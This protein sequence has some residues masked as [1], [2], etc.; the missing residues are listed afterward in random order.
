MFGFLAKLEQRPFGEVLRDLAQAAG[1]DLPE[2]SMSPAE[3]QAQLAAESERGQMLRAVEIATAFFEAEFA[4]PG[5]AA[6]RAYVQGRGLSPETVARFR[7]GFAPASWNALQS[8]LASKDVAIDVAERVGL[9]GTNERGHYAFFRDRVMLPVFDRQKRPVG[10]SSRLLDP[11]AKDRKYVN[12]PDSPLFH[13]KEQLYVLPLAI[14]AIRKSGTAVVVEGN[15]DVLSLHE[16]G[17]DEAVAPMGTALTSE[18]VAQ[19]ARIARRLVVVFDGDDAGRRAAHKAIPMF[20]DMDVDGRIAHMPAGV[21]PDDFVRK[22]GVKA[23]RLLIEQARPAVDQFI[24]DLS[25]KAVDGTV[26]ERLFLLDQAVPII[27]GVR[28]RTARELYAG[29]L[30]VTLGLTPDQVARVLRAG[31]RKPVASAAPPSPVAVAA[32]TPA[33]RV[34]ARD[35]LDSLLLLCAH[36]ELGASPDASRILDLLVDPGVRRMFRRAVEDTRAGLKPDLPAWLDAAPED[37]REAV[38]AALMEGRYDAVQGGPA[39]LASLCARLERS[40]IEAEISAMGRQHK[41]ALARGDEDAA[42]AISLREIELIRTKQGLQQS[43]QRP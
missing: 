4:A 31:S 5:G 20:V 32:P 38:S 36:P 33:T 41:D 43:H 7:V 40:R 23:L 14:E 12:S 10:F 26:P 3:R 34:P 39:T 25:K 9:V 30:P 37:I 42:R 2:K 16:A 19:L 29:R 13:K 8:H 24:D 11:D 21:D 28:N 35:E 6:A 22:E 15:F 18:Q 17:I 27:Q 1:V